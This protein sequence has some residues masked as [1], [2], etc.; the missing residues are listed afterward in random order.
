MNPPTSVLSA[1]HF[2]FRSRL[3][4][5]LDEIKSPAP[6]A[7]FYKLDTITDP[8]IYVGDYGPIG[9]PLSN[10]DAQ[11]IIG[12]SHQAPFCKGSETIVDSS[13][14]NTWELNSEQ[15]ELRNSERRISWVIFLPRYPKSLGLDP[16]RRRWM[17][18]FTKCSCTTKEPCSKLTKSKLKREFQ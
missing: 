2:G 17:R 18:S 9:L 12:A 5:Q 6:F 8:Q 16:K 10:D 15:F 7:S 13:V 11:V 1:N 4:Q 3:G 14:R